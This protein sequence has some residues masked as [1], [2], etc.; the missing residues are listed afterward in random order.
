MKKFYKYIFICIIFLAGFLRLWQIGVV[1]ASPDWDEVGLGYSAYSLLHTAKDEHGKLLPFVLESFGDYKPA[2]YA[3]LIIPFIFLL[4]LSITAVRL[5]SAILGILTVAA[6]YFLVF[7]LFK[8]RGL[9]LVSAFF[10]AIAPWHIQFSRVGFEASVGV[11]LNVFTALFFLKGLKKPHYL[12]LA[13]FSAGMSIYT[14]QSEKIFMP[15]FLLILITV[16]FKQIIKIPKIYLLSVAGF[17]GLIILPMFLYTTISPQGFARARST[18]IF[19]RDVERIESLNKR[20]LYNQ[21]QKDSV[22]LIFDNKIIFYGKQITGGYLAHFDPNWLFIKGDIARHHPPNMGLLYL[23][24]L[25]LLLVGIF[26]M[27]CI[28][29]PTSKDKKPYIFLLLWFFAAPLAAAI[30]LDVPHAVRSMNFLPTF[31]IFIAIGFVSIALNLVYKIK[32]RFLGYGILSMVVVFMVFNFVYYFNQYFVQLNKFNASDWQYGYKELVTEVEN[33]KGEYE[34][35]V[36][37]AISPM[38]QSYIFFLF[39]TKYP[40]G[41]FQKLQESGTNN[42]N[43]YEFRPL[44]WE[45]DKYDKSTLFVGAT[46]QFPIDVKAL[47]TIYYPNGQPAMKIVAP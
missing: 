38:D 14:Y 15:I 43:K 19:T 29:L 20:I 27:T 9:A 12:F 41:E 10:L 26:V 18:S 47:K 28:W 2:L 8:R 33:I 30:T 44:D 35:I 25:P 4:D 24:E 13:A 37:S 39:Y 1:P 36:I 11:A 5:P 6:T 46:N 42:F 7:E 23:V 16:Y 21:E 17:L 3:Y 32:P 40:P 34:N 22:S 31:Q 45:R